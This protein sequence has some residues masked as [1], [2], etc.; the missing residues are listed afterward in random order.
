[1]KNITEIIPEINYPV[2]EN[3]QRC[4]STQTHRCVLRTAQSPIYYQLAVFIV[5]FVL[6]QCLSV[7]A[8]KQD[9]LEGSLA[10]F[11]CS[12]GFE[13]FANAPESEGTMRVA[14]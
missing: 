2:P 4:S 1:M 13:R 8:L 5:S 3:R 7:C 12:V 10:K 6:M 9:G 14:F 11:G